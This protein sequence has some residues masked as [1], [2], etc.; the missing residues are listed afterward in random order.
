MEV[1]DHQGNWQLVK[2]L[3]NGKFNKEEDNSEHFG[4]EYYQLKYPFQMK[5]KI[6]V[7]KAIRDELRSICFL[8]SP[9]LPEDISTELVNVMGHKAISDKNNFSIDYKSHYNCLNFEFL[10]NLYENHYSRWKSLIKRNIEYEKN[11]AIISKIEEAKNEIVSLIKPHEIPEEHS[12]NSKEENCYEDGV[13]YA[14]EEEL[15][16]LMELREE[17]ELLRHYAIVYTGDQFIH[18]ENIRVY[19]FFE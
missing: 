11:N 9:K 19:C 3:E 18:S 12:I 5:K 8:N 14:I 10:E 17:I 2:Y 1:K 6:Y 15:E 4:E 16:T 13:D 7:G